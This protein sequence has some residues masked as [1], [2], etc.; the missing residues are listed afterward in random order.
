MK[1]K[2]Y[3]DYQKLPLNVNKLNEKKK[4]YKETTIKKKKKKQVEQNK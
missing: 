1:K 4:G 3:S 2:R